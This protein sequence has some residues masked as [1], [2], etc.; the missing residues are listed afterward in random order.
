MVF[1]TFDIYLKFDSFLYMTLSFFRQRCEV[2]LEILSEFDAEWRRKYW[3]TLSI[4]PSLPPLERDG[5]HLKQVIM[6]LFINAGDVLKD[7][8]RQ[9]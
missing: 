9:L 1:I 6:N 4:A 5:A 7:A 2:L 3:I 8:D